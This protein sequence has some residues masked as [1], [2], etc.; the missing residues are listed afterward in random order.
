MHNLYRL[1]SFAFVFE[2]PF[3]MHVLATLRLLT[4]NTRTSVWQNT[5]IFIFYDCLLKHII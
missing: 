5:F 3:E 2:F 1:E 4:D